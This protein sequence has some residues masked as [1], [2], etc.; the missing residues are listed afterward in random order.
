M[1][2]NK[3]LSTPARMGVI[4]GLVYCFLIFCQDQ[5]FYK[6]PLQFASTK[7]FCYLII[8]FGIFYTGLLSRKRSGGYITFQQCLKAMLLVIAIA[9]LFYL[10]FSTVYIKYIDPQFFIKLKTAWTDYYI[11]NGFP[12]DKINDTLQKFNDAGQ[13]NIWGL[14]QSYGFSIIIDAVFAVIFAAILKKERKFVENE[15]Q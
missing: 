15:I 9:E 8:L 7:L 13:I 11:K 2:T 12:Q 14:V 10:V 3:T 4:I 6:N 1:G 5:F